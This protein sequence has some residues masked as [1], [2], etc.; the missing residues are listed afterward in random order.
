M[1]TLHIFIADD[2]IP[3]SKLP[4]QEFRKRLFAEYGDNAQNRRFFEQCVFMGEIVQGLRDSGYRVTVAHTYADAVKEISRGEF[5]LAIIDLGWFMDFSIPEKERPAAGWSLCQHLDE[6]DERS[7]K[8]TPQILFSSRFPDEPELSREAARRQKL[9]I[10]KEATDTVRNSLMAAVGFVDA[11][12]TAQR[13]ASSTRSE[14][15]DYELQ[16]IAL[17]H[18]KEPLQDY[19][20]WTFLTLTF[21][22]ISLA[23]LVAG[24]ALAYTHTL[25]VAT[26][27]SVTSLVSGTIS[28]LLYKH[29]GSAQAAVE[30][31]QRE[32]LEQLK[33]RS[34]QVG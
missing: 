15:F 20:R 4:E 25:Q 32:V 19:R 6:K 18:F 11:T 16:N 23:L 1:P 17:S 9:P 2:Q 10:F 28:A 34:S 12:L 27:S 24:V 21:V 13:S 29:L 14:H 3:P 8:R 5:D 30:N 31:A 7:G 22:A 33:G 26:L